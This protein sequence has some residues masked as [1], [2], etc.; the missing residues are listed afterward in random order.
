[1]RP[2]M[3]GYV[4]DLVP[5]EKCTIRS[6][7]RNV[8]KRT[9]LHVAK[10]IHRYTHTSSDEMRNIRRCAG[11]LSQEVIQECDKIYEACPNCA[12]SGGPVER[13]KVSIAPVSTAFNDEVQAD[14]IYASIEGKK[15]EGLNI[16]DIGI[17]CGERVI[18]TSSSGEAIKNAFEKLSVYRHGATKYFSVDYEFCRTTLRRFME[19]HDIKV[20]P[21][22]NWSSHKPG[23]AEKN[24]EVLKK[25]LPN[26]ERA[27]RISD[28]ETMIAGSSLTTN[29]FYGSKLMNPFQLARRYTPYL[30][31]LPN[32]MVSQD[33][34]DTYTIREATQAVEKVLRA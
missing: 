16:V 6:L 14:F 31:G 11:D 12:S 13:R 26:L 24:N 5:R 25:R 8:E 20:R 30:L 1:M 21:R 17:K 19:K 28:P 3:R 10:K 4:L 18:V 23:R 33:L 34:L 9:E 15:Q 22:P 29:P 27:D 32:G 7:L 2:R